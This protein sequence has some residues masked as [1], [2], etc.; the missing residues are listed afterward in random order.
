[1]IELNSLVK[2]PNHEY[3]IFPASCCFWDRA[4]CFQFAVAVLDSGQAE[5]TEQRTPNIQSDSEASS[6]PENS[7]EEEESRTPSRS[8][9]SWDAPPEPSRL[10]AEGAQ[11]L[12]VCCNVSVNLQTSYRRLWLTMTKKRTI[13]AMMMVTPAADDMT[14]Y[15]RRLM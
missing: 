10:R 9:S 15:R 7:T 4:V 11:F 13:R 6:R 14:M 5:L 2:T 3:S 1:M 12:T 8:S